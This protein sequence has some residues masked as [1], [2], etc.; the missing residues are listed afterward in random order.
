MRIAAIDQGTTSTRLLVV[1]DGAAGSAT[2][3][4]TA[5]TIRSPAGSSTTRWSCWPMSAP[6]PRRRGR[7]RRSGS[8]IRAR[9]ASPGTG[10]P[11]SRCRRSIV[12]QDNRTGEA[13]ERLR[14][15]GAEALTLERAGLPLD[16]YFSAT[17]LAW[18]LA[19]VEPAQRRRLRLGTTDAWFLDR[20]TGRFATDVTTASRTSLMNLATCSWDEELCRLF[21]V[22]VECLPEIRPTVGRVRRHRRGPGHRRHGRPAGGALRPWLPG[23]GRRQGHLRHRRLRPGG[24]RRARS[25]GR[26]SAA[27]CRPWPGASARETVHAVDG[28]VYDAGAAVEWAGRLGLF[29]GPGRARRVRRA[30]GD[31][32]RARLRAGPV[33]PRLPAL[34]PQRRGLVARHVRRHDPAR[35]VPGAARGH[36]PAHGR[37]RRGHGRAGRAGPSSCR[38]TAASR[39]AP[40][41][42]SSW[43]TPPAA[44]CSG[45]GFDELTAFGC[46]A[47]AARGLG[48]TLA[49][50]DA[51]QR[52][53]SS[54]A[55]RMRPAG[56][57]RFADA[58]SRARGLAL[59]G[60]RR[61][62]HV[63]DRRRARGQHHQPVEAQRD[64]AGRRHQGQ[65]GEEVLV[66]RVALAV[67]PLLQRHLGLEAAALLDRVGQLA[68]AVGELDAAG[69]EL[70][71][72][73]HARVAGLGPG[74]RRLGDRVLAQDGRPAVAEPRLDPLDQH[75]AEHVRPAVVGG[76]PDA[77][78]AWRLRPAPRGRC[79]R[80]VDRGQQVDA[81]EARGTPRPRVSR[82][83]SATRDRPS[84]RGTPGSCAPTAAAAAARSSAQ[85][86]ISAS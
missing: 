67:E 4:A 16:P 30:A 55:A 17:K 42:P 34:G 61:P 64:A 49:M 47:L 57:S 7:W 84:G 3:S 79:A 41:S 15:D 11:A 43:P 50:P 82:S 68:E 85:S 74:Q 8:T 45:R 20:L 18:L 70:E 5:S 66:Q 73:G 81:G 52:R 36:R 86:A 75:A 44:P 9:A 12:W 26:P 59:S 31:R 72:L 40:T 38:S 56:A 22:P 32:A 48:V 14:A 76:D 33:R 46:A 63:L 13:I 39:A 25:C 51:W 53:C 37:G 21:G 80:R 77:G 29:D 6:A 60:D 24:H 62:Q 19:R 28:G 27:C 78:R 71:P 83:G 10:P 65:G 35:P 58:V 23:A 54:R 69:I 1:E 2:P